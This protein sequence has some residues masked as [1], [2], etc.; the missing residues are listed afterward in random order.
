MAE[1]VVNY[2]TIVSDLPKMGADSPSH[3]H[4][5]NKQ[6]LDGTAVEHVECRERNDLIGQNSW[7]IYTLLCPIL[8][9]ISRY[10]LN[11]L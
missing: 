4:N 10:F 2:S 1:V 5:Q 3:K 7:D 9:E 11:I 6:L 8:H